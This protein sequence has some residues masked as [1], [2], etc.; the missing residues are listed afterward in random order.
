MRIYCR[1]WGLATVVAAIAYNDSATFERAVS[2]WAQM[3][4]YVVTPA[5]AAAG[6][7]PSRSVPIKPTC[8]GGKTPISQANLPSFWNSSI[9]YQRR[10]QALYSWY[11]S[12]KAL[13]LVLI[14]ICLPFRIGGLIKRSLRLLANPLGKPELSTSLCNASRSSLF[15]L[16]YVCDVSSMN[17]HNLI[18]S[19]SP[20]RLSSYLYEATQNETYRDAAELSAEFTWNQLY[21]GKIILDT[22][23]LDDCGRSAAPMTHNSGIFMEGLIK[24]SSWNTSWVPRYV[25][26]CWTMLA[27]RSPSHSPIYSRLNSLISTTIPFSAWTN[28]EGINIEGMQHPCTLWR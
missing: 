16:Q 2:A 18:C 8:N 6:T 7:H 19:L 22:I 13:F 11:R 4:I 10:R 17:L 20:V 28:A 1:R 3:E 14:D 15:P 21:N 12:C 26:M 5:N 24:L 27:L 23:S 9:L 25:H